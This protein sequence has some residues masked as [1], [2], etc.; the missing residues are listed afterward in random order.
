MAFTASDVA[1]LRETTGAGM[2][3][4]KK[5]LTATDGDMEKAAEYLREQG[6]NIVA[7]KASRIASEGVVSAAISSDK[8]VGALVEINCE[9]DFVAKNEVFSQLASKISQQVIDANPAD[10]DALLA[11]KSATG[12]VADL[13]T[14]A[15]ANIGEKLSLRRFVRFENKNAHQEAYIHMGGKIGVLLEVATSKN[16]SGDAEF[17]AMCHDI[18]MH[19]AAMSPSYVCPKCVPADVVNKEKEILLAQASNDESFKKKPAQVQEKIIDGKISKFYKEVC[20]VEQEFVKDSSVSVGK[21]VENYGK[22]VG[23]D[24]KIVKFERLVMGEGLEKKVDNLA[25]EVAKIQGK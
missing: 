19:V 5:A 12:T 16:L 8:T 21:L 17:S 9:T 7:K 1:K 10:V 22:K 6:V 14:E 3:D 13:I 18:A 24:I 11:S 15:T 2:M 25:E 20:L 4:C 23:A